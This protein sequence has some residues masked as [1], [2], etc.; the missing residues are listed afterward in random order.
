M[1]CKKRLELSEAYYDALGRQPW[2]SERL[3]KIRDGGDEQSVGTAEL[4]EKIALD[5]L[6]DAW[7]AMNHHSC[8]LCR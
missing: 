7:Q 1:N 3:V 2:I 8:P 4:Q 5:E 6:Y